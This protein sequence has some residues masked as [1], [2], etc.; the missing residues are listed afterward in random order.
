M[1][2]SP[3]PSPPGLTR[4]QKAAIVVHLLLTEGADPGVSELPP[5][6][7]K[8]LVNALA[9]LRFVDRETLAEIIAEFT[10]ELDV[11]GLR[12]PGKMPEILSLLDG[13][14]S[15]EVL[16][17]MAAGLGDAPVAGLGSAAWDAMSRMPGDQLSVFLTSETPEIAAILL[18]KLPPA[19]AASLLAELE[20]GR[21]A[22]IAAAFAGTESVSPE[23]IARIGMSLGTGAGAAPSKGFDTPPVERVGAILNAATS[24]AR[25]DILASLDAS[26]PDFAA[27]VRGAVFSWENIPER[28]DPSD[29]PAVLREVDSKTIVA[30]LAQAPEGDV[31]T[32]ILTAISPRLADQYR[33]EIEDRGKVDASE[34]EEA[35]ATI[36]AAVRTMEASGKLSFKS[37]EE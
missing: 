9:S 37:P 35:Q 36:A 33:L 18:S 4:T 14:I 16:A 8:R 29:M 30:A 3:V 27:R 17:E 10:R 23:A 19:R 15:A 1:H 28:I 5:D 11:S 12:L 24:G 7:Q 2:H 25:G 31:S 32:Y 21:A 20:P 22:D 34:S 26:A 6:A 13:A